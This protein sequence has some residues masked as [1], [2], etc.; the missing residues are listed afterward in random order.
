MRHSVDSTYLTLGARYLRRQIRQLT[1]QLA[2]ARLGEDVECVHRA[3]VATRRLRT[4][5]R[6]FRDGWS[7]KRVKRW[8]REIRRVTES[9]GAAR[10][11]DVQIE[12]LYGILR[13]AERPECAPGLVRLL[14]DVQ[15]E[16]DALE[17]AVL[18]AA[19]R[20][21]ASRVLDEIRSA[22]KKVISRALPDQ[23]PCG[24]AAYRQ[25]GRFVLE[26]LEQ[27]LARQQS[28]DD[29][30]DCE[31]HHAL[32]IA[33]KRLRYT[34][35]AAKPLCAGQLDEF[36]EAARKLQTLL[37]DV[38]DCD[39]W[40]E[41]LGEFARRESARVGRRF[42]SEG[43]F[44]RLVPGIEYVRSE[45]AGHRTAVFQELGRCWRELEERQTWQRLKEILRCQAGDDTRQA[46]AAGQPLAGTSPQ[47]PAVSPGLPAASGQPLGSLPPAVSAASAPAAPAAPAASNGGQRTIPRPKA[48][49]EPSRRAML[50]ARG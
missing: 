38:H 3:R 42:G 15:R 44:T 6:M 19:E 29:P 50:L 43:R 2:G 21:E 32:R 16:R 17:P 40:Q 35:E 33:V 28:L 23:E 31:A 1:E 12:F 45:R 10:D 13:A 24:S 25:A 27:L 30:Q 48:L 47:A 11:K 9:L 8:R 20:I 7:S 18:E 37:G 14:A 26:R 4:A 5:L 49:A 22:A 46:P 36:L 41:Q 39:V 34:L